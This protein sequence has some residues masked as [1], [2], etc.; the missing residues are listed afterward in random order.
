MSESGRPS[1][2]LDRASDPPP[3][4][5]SVPS[6]P[7][8]PT[9]K[10]PMLPFE[11]VDEAHEWPEEP[12]QVM[13]A[14]APGTFFADR[15]RIERMLGMGGMSRV[16]E[17]TDLRIERRV[18]LKV[19]YPRRRA[20]DEVVGRFRREAE[21]LARLDH[22]GVVRVR[23]FGQAADGTTWLSMDLLEGETLSKRLRRE[24]RM[25]PGALVPI[26][27]A[28]ADALE[29]AHAA[30]IVHRDLKPDNVFLPSSGSPPAM[31]LDFG[32]STASGVARLT[33]TGTVVGTPR[34]MAPEQLRSASDAGPRA[35]VY[36]LG[37]LLY[38]ALTGTS[39]FEAADR[40]EL[41]GAILQGRRVP[42]RQRR[43]ELPAAIEQVLERAMHRD[44]EARFEGPKALAEAFAEALGRASYL[45]GGAPSAAV[46]SAP[47]AGRPTWVLLAAGLL[48]GILIG[49]L[50][51]WLLLRP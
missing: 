44:P 18:A 32:L 13:P 5:P 3:T 34:Y 16:Y 22:P 47:A 9:E 27:A 31:V 1:L 12:T 30:G 19:L 35:D 38:E 15:F 40:G 37:V 10:L 23:D 48:V 24:K 20:D 29:A 21:L 6:E 7:S 17:A 41:L 51:V 2:P 33:R 49:G 25:G 14:F 4:V 46:A 36:A 11:G 45:P 43:P 8:E 50:G 26:V 42:L 39:P 28:V